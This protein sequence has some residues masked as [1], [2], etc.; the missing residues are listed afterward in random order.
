MLGAW[1]EVNVQELDALI[2]EIHSER[3][4]DMSRAVPFVRRCA[5]R[6]SGAAGAW[7]SP[8]R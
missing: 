7:L 5:W 3:A 8:R 1:R 2:A 4:R 6:G